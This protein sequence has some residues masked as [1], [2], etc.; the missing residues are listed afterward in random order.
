MAAR[1]AAAT[2]STERSQRA[3]SNLMKMIPKS[4]SNN[5]VGVGLVSA[6]LHAAVNVA[7]GRTGAGRGKLCPYTLFGVVVLALALMLGAACERKGV[8]PAPPPA[9]PAASSPLRPTPPG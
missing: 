1:A 2:A 7:R 8:T 3:L 6:R 4:E 9:K 5:A